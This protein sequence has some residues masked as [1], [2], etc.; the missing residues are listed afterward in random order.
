[1]SGSEDIIYD[2]RC[3]CLSNIF[4]NQVFKLAQKH[5][6]CLEL[7]MSYAFD[8]CSEDHKAMCADI[9]HFC[10]TYSSLLRE[11]EMLPDASKTA[12][13]KVNRAVWSTL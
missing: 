13:A 1:M 11:I 3:A 8:A 6:P 7:C 2:K 5:S 10:A 4:E 9:S 12:E